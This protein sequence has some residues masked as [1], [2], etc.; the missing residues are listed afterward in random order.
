MI[1]IDRETDMTA[2]PLSLHKTHGRAIVTLATAVLAA[3]AGCGGG[4]GSPAADGSA[5]G[6]DAHAMNGVGSGGT[7]RSMSI[8][9][10]TALSASS[11]IASAQ[12]AGKGGGGTLTVNGVA[13]AD[14]GARVTDDEGRVRSLAD[15]HVGSAVWVASGS[16]AAENAVASAIQITTDVVGATDSPYDAAHQR[17][18]VM[19]QPV[20]VNAATALDAFPGGVASI[21][22]GTVVEVSSMYDAA[23]G[24]YVATRL[25]PAAGATHYKVRGAATS[26]DNKAHT[27]RIG[28]QAFTFAGVAGAP[29]LSN[30]QAVAVDTLLRRNTAGQWVVT[31]FV[32]AV[33]T[34]MDGT[35]IDLSGVVAPVIDATHFSVSGV[36]VDASHAMVSPLG[37]VIRPG[38]RVTL[39]GAMSE[40]TLGATSVVVNAE[41]DDDQGGDGNSQH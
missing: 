11:R 33:A 13:Y 5:S 14:A 38:V 34:P 18:T 22:T 36:A 23:T 35:T 39:S 27:F 3:L 9:P 29:R 40:S 26:V 10:V 41:D 24:N 31:S 4:S 37:A 17:L 6:A 8:G 21:G 20:V 7:G 28:G 12:P 1:R 15:L 30:N 25:D 16:V 2:H 32:V 19:G